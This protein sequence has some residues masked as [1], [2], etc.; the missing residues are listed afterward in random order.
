MPPQ[1]EQRA[2]LSRK[3]YWEVI[4]FMLLSR[5]VALPPEGANDANAA[6]LKL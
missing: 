6:G 5:G 1:S 3:N 4:N 2:T